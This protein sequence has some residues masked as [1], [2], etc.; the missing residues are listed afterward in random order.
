M[1]YS[2]TF[3]SILF[4]LASLSLLYQSSMSTLAN[5]ES[6]AREGKDHLIIGTIGSPTL[7]NP[8]FSADSSSG[9]VEALLFNGLITYDAKA[10]ADSGFSGKL[11][12]IR[13]WL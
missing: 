3:L 5:S 4:V 12:S 13:G 1:N 6:G 2:R 7:F 9:Q 8:Y 10:S 11:G